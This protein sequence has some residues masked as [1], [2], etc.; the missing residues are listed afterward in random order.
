M[1][2]TKR[3][4]AE[5]TRDYYQDTVA[6]TAAAGKPGSA[7]KGGRRRKNE[8][9]LTIENKPQTY[10]LRKT[11]TTILR[12]RVCSLLSLARWKKAGKPITEHV[13][14]PAGRR[15]NVNAVTGRW[16]GG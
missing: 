4:Y 1:P 8:N 15:R 9:E 6:K 10:K 13:R 14:R 3:R 7:R 2:E 12:G 5:I 11:K 16:A